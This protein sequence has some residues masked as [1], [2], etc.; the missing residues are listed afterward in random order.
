MAPTKGNAKSKKTRPKKAGTEARRDEEWVSSC[1]GEAE[2]NGL[3]EA[4]VLPDRATAGWLSALGEPFPTPHTDEVVVFKD[5]FWR[6]LGF[7]FTHSLGI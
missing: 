2:L 3:V 6:G 4:G 5:Y 7:L 1:T